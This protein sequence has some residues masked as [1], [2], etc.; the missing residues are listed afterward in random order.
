MKKSHI[1]FLA[2][3][4]AGAILSVGIVATIGLIGYVIVVEK[5]NSVNG[6]AVI[7]NVSEPSG[8]NHYQHE[9]IAKVVD[10]KI[11]YMNVG[12]SSCPPILDRAIYDA[13]YD[14]YVLTVKS[15][16]NQP[17]TKDIKALKQT[18]SQ[19]GEQII[20]EN[21]DIEILYED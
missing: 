19:D 9:P 21:A 3:A 13:E 7:L 20:P 11:V 15:Y 8:S 17:C 5:E 10:G 14:R 16:K 12:S 4:G 1:V 2:L 18:V 6:D